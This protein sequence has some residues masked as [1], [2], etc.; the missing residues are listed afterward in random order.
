VK[1]PFVVEGMIQGGLGGTVA[2][3]LLWLALRWLSRDL[4]SSELLGRTA[5]A[6]APEVAALLILGGM[7]VGVAG[8]L[9]SMT[10]LR[11]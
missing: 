8:S 9:V 5:F 1:G 2:A 11:V 4:A 7:V 3:G 6:L 10:R